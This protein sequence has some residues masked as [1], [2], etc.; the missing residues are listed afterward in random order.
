MLCQGEQARLWNLKTPKHLVS[1][2]GRPL[3][4]R[5]IEM[6]RA[7][8]IQDIIINADD[9]EAWTKFAWDQKL[10]LVP[11]FDKKPDQDFLDVLVH[12]RALWNTSGPTLWIY[13]DT[14]FSNRMMDELCRGRT[15]DIFF[16]TRFSP[17]PPLGKWRAEI[18]GWTMQARY[19][20]SL[21]SFLRVR[22]CSPYHK[23][24][25]VWS[26]FHYLMDRRDNEE[27]DAAFLDAGE[28]DYTFD[29][30]YEGD[31]ADLSLLEMLAQDDDTQTREGRR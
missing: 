30:D 17:F 18:F 7:R 16:A 14:V 12:F 8:G 20:E 29:L 3:L 9:T 10:Q 1:F 22:Q 15:N 19:H 28:E 23:A 24:T 5:T 6:L 13:G 25:D 26:L 27:R 31:L 4:A 21:D 2:N 11:E